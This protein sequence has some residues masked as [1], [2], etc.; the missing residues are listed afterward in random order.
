[1]PFYSICSKWWSLKKRLK[2]QPNDFCLN[3]TIPV[4]TYTCIYIYIYPHT[5]IGVYIYICISVWNYRNPF[6]II[7]SKPIWDNHICH[8]CW[9]NQVVVQFFLCGYHQNFYKRVKLAWW[10]VKLIT[11]I[12]KCRW[13][14]LFASL[15]LLNCFTFHEYESMIVSSCLAIDIL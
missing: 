1:M 5:C 9:R 3:I 8:K 11:V 14:Y 15:C 4:G 13:F 6:G 12:R 10:N 2:T 7:I